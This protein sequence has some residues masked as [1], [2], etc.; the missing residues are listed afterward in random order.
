MLWT[1]VEFALRDKGERETVIRVHLL[2]VPVTQNTFEGG[3]GGG[4]QTIMKQAKG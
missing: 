1:K 2:G 3:G 4:G